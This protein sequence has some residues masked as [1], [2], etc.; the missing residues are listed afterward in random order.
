MEDIRSLRSESTG[1][2]G[3]KAVAPIV[4]MEDAALRYAQRR[5]RILPLHGIRNDCCTCGRDDCVKPGKH[6]HIWDWVNAA[7]SDRR[8]IREW[9]TRWPNANIGGATG[10]LL[11][12]DIDPKKGGR[13][14]L[15][16]L[17]AQDGPLPS[18]WRSQTGG[19]GAHIFFCQPTDEPPLGN[20]TGR[21]GPGL[22]T[23]GAGGYVVLPPSRHV[24]GQRYRW[25]ATGPLAP[26]PPWLLARLRDA[27][28]DYRERFRLPDILPEGLRNDH[29]YR[30]ARSL[31]AQ[32]F[33]ATEMLAAAEVINA[34]RCRPPLPDA[35]IQAI[36]EHAAAQGD[37][38]AFLGRSGTLSEKS[39]DGHRIYVFHARVVP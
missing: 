4:T 37:S 14:S 7:T 9:W 17:E 39:G 8:T 31:R 38:P 27:P 32:G 24:S 5:W 6:P 36:V 11:V 28:A 20:S 18:T 30:L 25:T 16:R 29:L 19:D 21:L 33:T 12:V 23:R 26:A 2:P 22:D 1:D 10:E 35:E 15:A 3:S 34:A 13:A